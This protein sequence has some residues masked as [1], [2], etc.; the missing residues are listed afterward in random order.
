MLENDTDLQLSIVD[1]V[2]R[3]FLM[4]SDAVKY[5]NTDSF[6]ERGIIDST[7]VLELV[8]FI[9]QTF[10]ITVNDEDLIPENLDSVNNLVCYIKRKKTTGS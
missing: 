10:K 5:S 7:G 6:M 1:F 4:N 9:Q 3:N 8:N 2:N